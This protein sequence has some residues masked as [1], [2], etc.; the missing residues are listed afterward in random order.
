MSLIRMQGLGCHGVCSLEIRCRG[1][2]SSLGHG[3]SFHRCPSYAE[4]ERSNCQIIFPSYTGKYSSSISDAARTSYPDRE[5]ITP[6]SLR[7]QF[8]VWRSEFLQ[9]EHERTT[10][11]LRRDLRRWLPEVETVPSDVADGVEMILS[12]EAWNRLRIEQKL[13]LRRAT[14]VMRLAVLALMEKHVVHV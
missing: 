14:G 11:V 10:R 9:E 4:K 3:S 2:I 8:S 7:P 13:G 12:F 1:R 5:R 6:F